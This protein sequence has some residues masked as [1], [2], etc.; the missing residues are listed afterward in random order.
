[1]NT[2]RR[3]AQ[4][5]S[6]PAGRQASKYMTCRSIAIV[7]AYNNG[8]SNGDSNDYSND[9]NNVQ[10]LHLVQFVFPFSPRD[11]DRLHGVGRLGDLSTPHPRT[12]PAVPSAR[13]PAFH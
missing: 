7:R 11:A 3:Q 12:G 5:P 9:Y 10:H 4:G 6:R 1:M 13:L 8:D 2:P